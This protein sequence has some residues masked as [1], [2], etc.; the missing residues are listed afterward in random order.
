MPKR[1]DRVRLLANIPDCHWLVAGDI[2]EVQCAALIYNT[3]S[4]DEF[5]VHLFVPEQQP[6]AVPLRLLKPVAID[7]PEQ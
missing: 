6:V 1:G 4:N 2:Y 7:A 5:A 3:P